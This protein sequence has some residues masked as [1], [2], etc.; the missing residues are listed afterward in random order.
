MYSVVTMTFPISDANKITTIT[1]I[2]IIKS[3][4]IELELGGQLEIDGNVAVVSGREDDKIGVVDRIISKGS[5]ISS[6]I[7]RENFDSPSTVSSMLPLALLCTL[8]LTV[9]VTLVASGMSGS[10]AL[11]ESTSPFCT[12]C[13][14]RT[15]RETVYS[16]VSMVILSLVHVTMVG[17]PLEESNERV[18]TGGSA[19][20]ED[21][22]ANCI[23]VSTPG[24]SA[25]IHSSIIIIANK[26]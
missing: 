13:D 9:T 10:D 17:G 1:A 24:P 8:S 20:R 26:N 23:L 19:S 7:Q 11:T 6:K 14:R 2:A 5:V 15:S 18:K 22:R 12:Y 4:D 16:D 25:C 3:L 21:M